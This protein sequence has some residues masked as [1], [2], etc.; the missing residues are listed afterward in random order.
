MAQALNITDSD[1]IEQIA[2]SHLREDQKKDLSGLV[3]EMTEEER[4]ELLNLIEK[5]NAD[6]DDFETK[7]KE[8][9]AA[10]N[11][12]HIDKLNE[13]AH[14]ESEYVRSEF[15]KFDKEESAEEMKEVEAALTT[16]A[17]TKS[18]MKS[19]Q[20]KTQIKQIKKHPLFKLFLFLLSIA[21]IV[22]GLIYGIQY[23]NTL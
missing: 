10:L 4:T 16:A 3:T 23:L 6:A 9:L 8:K 13:A 7:K 18:E 11:K 2:A 1:L 21:G 19:K 20:K 22:F 17:K 14:H 5:S 12:E 15:E